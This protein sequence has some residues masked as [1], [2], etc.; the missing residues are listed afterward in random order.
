MYPKSERVSECNLL[1]DRLRDKLE[2][3]SYSN[4]K[5]YYNIGD[6]KSAIYAFR[7]ANIDYPDNKYREEMLFLTVK[8]SYLYAKLSIDTKKSERFLE[9]IYY[10]QNFVDSYA[11]S[12]YLKEAQEIQ[13]DCIVKIETLKNLSK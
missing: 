6:Y 13:S 1:I 10:Y 3:K 5:M 12:K 4:A 11:S 2:S 9:T 7:N 8:S